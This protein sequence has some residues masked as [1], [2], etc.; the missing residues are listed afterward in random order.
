MLSIKSSMPFFF[1][2]PFFCDEIL[3]VVVAE[4]Y[5]S[6]DLISEWDVIMMVN[7]STL[8][9]DGLKGQGT[10]R[11]RRRQRSCSHLPTCGWIGYGD[12]LARIA[13]YPQRLLQARWNGYSFILL[14]VWYYFIHIDECKEW[15]YLLIRVLLVIDHI[16]GTDFGNNSDGRKSQI[17]LKQ[18]E[19]LESKKLCYC[20]III[21]VSI[22]ILTRIELIMNW[23]VVQRL[24]CNQ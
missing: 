10:R 14:P 1:S 24:A 15:F 4:A 8:I 2:F 9:C 11:V 16:T 7:N 19:Y 3:F 12:R 6:H 23:R 22:E 18:L 21:W 5:S 17:S 20:V 13:A